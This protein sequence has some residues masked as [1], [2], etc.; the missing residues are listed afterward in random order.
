MCKILW[1]DSSRDREM[2]R[3]DPDTHTDAECLQAKHPMRATACN[4]CRRKKLRWDHGTPCKNCQRAKKGSYGND[5]PK[6]EKIVG[7]SLPIHEDLRI[8]SRPTHGNFNINGR[9]IPLVKPTQA[10]PT[11]A[12]QTQAPKQQAGETWHELEIGS[13][14]VGRQRSPLE[15]DLPC[16]LQRH[17]IMRMDHTIEKGKAYGKILKMRLFPTKPNGQ[18]GQQLPEKDITDKILKLYIETFENTHH[19]LHILTLLKDYASFAQNPAGS[20]NSFLGQLQLCLALGA[21]TYDDHP[22]FS[23]T[24][25]VMD[26]R[27]GRLAGYQGVRTNAID[28]KNPA[29][30]PALGSPSGRC[31]EPPTEDQLDKF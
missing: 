2:S 26:S 4:E 6:S 24:S 12:E 16:P 7:I 27:S 22:F 25:H 15:T 10:R 28:I 5:R 29:Q 9:S 11:Q 1:F 19:I 14:L 18:Y 30:M 8:S 17:L 20:P 13:V 23:A 31:R 21:L 3:P